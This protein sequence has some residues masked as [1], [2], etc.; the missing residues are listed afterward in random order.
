[1]KD[2]IAYKYET[3][4]KRNPSSNTTLVLQNMANIVHTKRNNVLCCNM[5][6]LFFIYNLPLWKYLKSYKF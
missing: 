2:F 1:M 6:V 3:C 5:N 4:M